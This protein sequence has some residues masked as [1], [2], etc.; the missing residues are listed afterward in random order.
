M[1]KPIQQP[2]SSATAPAPIQ[3]PVDSIGQAPS[4]QDSTGQSSD[5]PRGIQSLQQKNREETPKEGEN[6]ES[7]VQ[8]VMDTYGIVKSELPKLL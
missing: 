6:E 4:L 1:K 3:Q 2:V 7:F 5:E 8:R